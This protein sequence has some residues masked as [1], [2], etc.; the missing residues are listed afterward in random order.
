M[1]DIYNIICENFMIAKEAKEE[2]ETSE[3]EEAKT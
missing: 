1:Y 2:R 3:M